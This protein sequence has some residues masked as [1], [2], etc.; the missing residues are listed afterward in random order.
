M[1]MRFTALLPLAIAILMLGWS[2]LNPLPPDTR[3]LYVEIA[4]R[5][6]FI[7]HIHHQ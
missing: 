2:K 6:F 7:Q 1:A 3:E 5:D 4:K